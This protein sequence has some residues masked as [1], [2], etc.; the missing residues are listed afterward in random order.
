MHFAGSPSLKKKNTKKNN[1][2][3][4]LRFTEE[5]AMEWAL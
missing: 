4:A 3:Y 2:E 1:P 5:E